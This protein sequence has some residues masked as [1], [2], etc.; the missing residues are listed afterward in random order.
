MREITGH[1]CPGLNDEI[2]IHV[3]DEPGPGGA[4]HLYSMKWKEK[5]AVRIYYVPFQK[6]PVPDFGANGTSNEALLAVVADRLECFQAG[7]FACHENAVALDAV[8]IA[9]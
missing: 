4:N 3:E 1:K 6:G 9:L 7:K 8:R 2:V 5:G